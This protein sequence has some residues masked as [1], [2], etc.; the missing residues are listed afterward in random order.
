[1][2]LLNMMMVMMTMMVMKTK[3]ICRN[4]E[5]N[6]AQQGKAVTT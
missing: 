2:L 3:S 4:L 5:Q 1:M 6:S